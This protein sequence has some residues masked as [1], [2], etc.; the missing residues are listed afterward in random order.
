ML[1]SGSK[2]T[3]K[4]LVS[5]RKCVRESERKRGCL[6]ERERKRERVFSFMIEFIWN[7]KRKCVRDGLEV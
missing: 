4:M 2:N 7:R 1:E 3:R 6:R 5:E